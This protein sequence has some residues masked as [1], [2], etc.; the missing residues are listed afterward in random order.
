MVPLQYFCNSD[1]CHLD[2]YHMNKCCLDACPLFLILISMFQMLRYTLVLV[3]FALTHFL[4]L[5]LFLI[6]V[7][8]MCV[9]KGLL[10]PDGILGVSGYSFSE[11]ITNTSLCLIRLR[12]SCFYRLIDFILLTDGFISG[13][14]SVSIILYKQKG[15]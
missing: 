14:Y 2:K 4:L 10:V 8:W 5:Y 13:C 6:E 1:N 12:Y 15:C 7:P 3:K 11:T 9:Y